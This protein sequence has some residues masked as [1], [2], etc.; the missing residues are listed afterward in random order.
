MAPVGIANYL[1][2]APL[3]RLTKST[4]EERN[5]FFDDVRALDCSLAIK[6]AK[7]CGAVA[8][9]SNMEVSFPVL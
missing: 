4:N 7:C 5:K 6:Q 2:C 1:V 8:S 3:K 9:E